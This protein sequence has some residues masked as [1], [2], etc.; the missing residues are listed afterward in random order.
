MAHQLPLPL[1]TDWGTLPVE[2]PCVNQLDELQALSDVSFVSTGSHRLGPTRGPLSDSPHKL[3]GGTPSGKMG[4]WERK[5]RGPARMVAR[6]R[7]S[8]APPNC[9]EF[10]LY[11]AGMRP[12]PVTTAS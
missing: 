11:Y 5:K 7:L 6:P 9:A 1:E 2:T 12:V 8:S 4:L 10:L 3:P